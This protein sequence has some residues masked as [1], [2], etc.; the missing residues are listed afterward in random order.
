METERAALPG[1]FNHNS[2]RGAAK[3][4]AFLAGSGQ[5]RPFSG[6][7]SRRQESR[8]NGS[9]LEWPHSWL[10]ADVA[11]QDLT[12]AIGHLPRAGLGSITTNGRTIPWEAS[13][14]N[15]NWL[16]R[17]GRHFWRPPKNE[18][19]TQVLA[20]PVR[21]KGLADADNKTVNTTFRRSP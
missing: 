2:A 7:E 3:R 8:S 11:L 20:H 4:L 16:L 14:R 15:K 1:S 21:S 6:P 19:I 17:R 12:P 9:D 10:C 13:P 5:Y 18:G